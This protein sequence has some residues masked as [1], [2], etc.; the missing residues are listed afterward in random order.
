MKP[1]ESIKLVGKLF[2]ISPSL[3]LAAVAVA[4]L[5]LSWYFKL[6]HVGVRESLPTTLLIAFKLHCKK[7]SIDLY[8]LLDCDAKPTTRDPGARSWRINDLIFLYW[9]LRVQGMVVIIFTCLLGFIIGALGVMHL[10]KPAE[11]ISLVHVSEVLSAVFSGCLFLLGGLSIM[12]LVGSI[13]RIPH[14]QLRKIKAWQLIL[15]AW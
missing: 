5:V 13:T 10:A 4:W 14:E 1:D 3:A 11:G 8:G 2:E 12:K 9:A 15:L 6:V 7:P